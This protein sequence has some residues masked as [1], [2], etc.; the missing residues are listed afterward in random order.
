MS[1]EK[2]FRY[3][4]LERTLPQWCRVVTLC[5]ALAGAYAAAHAAVGGQGETNL[6]ADVV[7][8]RMRAADA[9]RAET[10]Q[11]YTGRRVYTLDYHGFPGSK[12][13][14]M[15]VET[16]YIAPDQKEFRVISQ[17]GSKLLLDRVLLRLLEGEKEGSQSSNRRTAKLTPD[18]YEFQSQGLEETPQGVFYVLQ[19]EPK[20]KSKF[21]YR[22]RIWVSATD[23][24]VARIEA[25]PAK[26]PSFW[27]SHTR[28]SHQYSKVGEFWLPSRNQSETSVRLGGKGTLTIEYIDYVTH[29]QGTPESARSNLG[30]RSSESRSSGTNNQATNT[31]PG[32]GR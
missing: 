28:I 26:N 5:V 18:N 27:I 32:G 3:V 11:S 23:F 24:A 4:Q 29:A 13:A 9:H 8:E 30:E 19:V 16:S 25:E 7:V 10:L 14:E 21:L 6:P 12:H 15:V 17:T 2:W 1:S 22:G 31:T 20:T